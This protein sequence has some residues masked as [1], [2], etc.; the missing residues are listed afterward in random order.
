MFSGGVYNLALRAILI[1]ESPTKV[2]LPSSNMISEVSMTSPFPKCAVAPSMVIA[3]V[4]FGAGVCC[5]QPCMVRQ[6]V[7]SIN[8]Y[9][10]FFLF[11]VLDFV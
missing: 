10:S 9:F 8:L 3:S 1:L 4:C 2:I 5:A 7:T 11:L 6:H